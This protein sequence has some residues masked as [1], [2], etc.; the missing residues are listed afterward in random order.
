M[1]ESLIEDGQRGDMWESEDGSDGRDFV[2]ELFELVSWELEGLICEM[3]TERQ[4]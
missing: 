4:S 1:F 2:L 3:L